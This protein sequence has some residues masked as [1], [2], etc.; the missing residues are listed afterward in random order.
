MTTNI[1]FEKQMLM[2]DRIYGF[3]L[4]P[5]EQ[6]EDAPSDES[7]IQAYSFFCLRLLKLKELLPS[8]ELYPEY[9]PYQSFEGK[10]GMPRLHFHG[11][12]TLNSF[13]FYTGGY[14][15]L[16]NGNSFYF[17]EKPKIEYSQKNKSLMQKWCKHYKVPY[18]ITYKNLQSPKCFK[19]ISE[20]ADRAIISAKSSILFEII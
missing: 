1:P 17:S 20:W 13:K 16:S 5:L 8:V 10:A 15:H 3:T 2:D 14:R 18:K 19:I 4:N 6:C 12:T 9:S 7:F 11:S